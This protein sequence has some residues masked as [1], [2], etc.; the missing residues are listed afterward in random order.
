MV[1]KVP[2]DGMDGNN[3]QYNTIFECNK[4]FLSWLGA[5]VE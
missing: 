2:H 5:G 4:A 1:I 3:V